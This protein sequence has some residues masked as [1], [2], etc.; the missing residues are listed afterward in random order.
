VVRLE[1][2]LVVTPAPGLVVDGGVEV[3][4]PSAWGREYLSRHCLPV[5]SLVLPRVSFSDT[6]VQFFMPYFLIILMSLSSS[7]VGKEVPAMTSLSAITY[8][9]LLIFIVYQL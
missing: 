3:V 8:E 5:R 7:C 2:H 9:C 4:V 1:K 6:R